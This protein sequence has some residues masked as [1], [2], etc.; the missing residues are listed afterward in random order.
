MAS[1]QLTFDP[2]PGVGGGVASAVGGGALEH[3]RV[4]PPHVVDHQRPVVGEC[5]PHGLDAVQR[6]AVSIPRDLGLRSALHIAGNLQLLP[7]LTQSLQAQF[8]RQ[9]WLLCKEIK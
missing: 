7:Y 6:L 1:V 9:P 4:L 3:A 5:V 2:E 8:P